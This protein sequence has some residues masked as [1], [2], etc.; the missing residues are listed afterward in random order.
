MLWF[1]RLGSYLWY[2]KNVIWWAEENPTLLSDNLNKRSC[3]EDFSPKELWLK[4]WILVEK[5]FVPVENDGQGLWMLRVVGVSNPLQHLVEQII[6]RHFWSLPESI[7]GC[8]SQTSTN[9][10]TFPSIVIGGSTNNTSLPLLQVGSPGHWIPRSSHRETL[11]FDLESSRFS[12]TLYHLG[13]YGRLDRLIWQ[14]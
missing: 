10:T 1:C 3:W 9:N 7:I 8:A 6:S 2:F 13:M 14:L 5:Y 12:L 11:L 4:M